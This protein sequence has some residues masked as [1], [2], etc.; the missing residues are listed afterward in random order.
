MKT[1]TGMPGAPRSGSFNKGR[2]NGQ[3]HR[4]AP[5][6]RNPSKSD[7]RRPE[8]GYKAGR[9][10]WQGQTKASR[11]PFIKIIERGATAML[12]HFE[13]P[14]LGSLFR[15][16]STV[17]SSRNAVRSLLTAISLAV[18]VL[19]ANLLHAQQDAQGCKDSP[20]ISRFPGTI[21]N[22]CESKTTTP[23]ISSWG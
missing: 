20:Y 16:G 10:H 22:S 3:R 18:C 12:P 6:P 19:T 4:V 2:P 11:R 8:A 1:R 7:W 5:A 21:I 23:P 9:R 17:K 13:S 15:W 14:S